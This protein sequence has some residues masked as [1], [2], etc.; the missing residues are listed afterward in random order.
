MK[1]SL[2]TCIVPFYNEGK[3]IIP[4]LNVL[5]KVTNLASIVCV[6][7]GSEDEVYKE[8]QKVYKKEQVLVIRQPQNYGKSAA[9]KRGLEAVNTEY[10]MLID[11]DLTD[12]KAKEL[13][14]AV[15]AIEKDN[16]IDMIILRRK[17]D[18]W[19]SKVIRGDITVTGERIM[20]T[21]DLVAI[22]K[23]APEAYQ[24][25][26]AINL[27]M[28]EKKR[29]VYWMYH[30]GRN[31]P[32]VRKTGFLKGLLNELKMYRSI[33]AYAGFFPSLKVIATFAWEEV[34]QK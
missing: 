20:R 31:I 17:N 34:P 2:C 10:V 15:T 16:S 9:V 3:R 33:A 32:K 19:F 25:E 1:A 13:Q 11:A 28:M 27:Y 5:T 4:V 24:L 12:L 7:D 14:D 6:D 21:K 30:S 8:L 22:L 26:F 18:P 29:K 23:D